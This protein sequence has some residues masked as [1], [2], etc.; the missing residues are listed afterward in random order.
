M[1]VRRFPTHVEVLAPAKI[2][3]FLEVLGK[4]SDGFHEIETVLVAIRACDSLIFTPQVGGEIDLTC[5]WSMGLVGRDA[6]ASTGPSA[7]RELL[8]PDLPCGPENLA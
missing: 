6:A 8:F 4:R 7:A 5:Q 1:H 3:L 2:N